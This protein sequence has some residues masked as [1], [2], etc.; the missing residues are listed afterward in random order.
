MKNVKNTSEILVRGNEKGHCTCDGTRDVILPDHY[1]DIK[2]ILRATGIVSSSRANTDRSGVG[3]ECRLSVTVL[4]ID[5]SDI[6]RTF[7][8]SLDIIGNCPLDLPSQE[9]TLI[10]TAQLE[11]VS[12]K[13]VNPRKLGIKASVGFD[14]KI[15]DTLE[16]LPQMPPFFDSGILASVEKQSA[17]CLYTSLTEL[18]DHGVHVSRELE[19]DKNMLSIGEILSFSLTPEKV[20]LSCG[21]RSIACSTELA[22]ELIYLSDD[23]QICCMQKKIP[24][25]ATIDSDKIISETA[26]LGVCSVL[27]HE[28]R[29]IEDMTGQYRAILV[30]LKCGISVYAATI[31]EAEYVTDIYSTDFRTAC[32]RQKVK[33]SSP[34]TLEKVSM[35][36]QI[37]SPIDADGVAEILSVKGSSAVTS[38]VDKDDGRY[39]Y[40]TSTVTAL[41]KHADGTVSSVGIPDG[42][43]MRLPKCGEE[44]CVALFELDDADIS[45]GDLSVS[46]SVELSLLCWE[47]LSIDVVCKLQACETDRIVQGRPLTVYYPAPGETLWQVAK[48]YSIASDLLE[49]ANRGRDVGEALIIPRRRAAEGA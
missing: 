18:C 10:S 48:R 12:V 24:I 27:S 5:E 21:D 32:E 15:W 6:V 7:D 14:F 45:D 46:Y 43:E 30:D 39:C 25:S 41:V 31:A 19:L 37:S 38:F 34:A 47:N 13:A 2:K 17:P 40:V 28:C 9:L 36:R 16:T 8:T 49:A 11:S 29:P 4:F 3:F 1:G 33:Y 20:D 35:R 26:A 44:L 23:R 22:A 42:F